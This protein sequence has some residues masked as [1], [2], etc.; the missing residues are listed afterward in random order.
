ML[1]FWHTY[2]QLK[3]VSCLFVLGLGLVACAIPGNYS[4]DNPPTSPPAELQIE[5]GFTISPLITGLDQPT[6]LAFDPQGRLYIAQRS[7][8][9]LIKEGADPPREYATGFNKPLSLHWFEQ[10]LYV[11]EQGQI[12]RLSDNNGDGIVDQQTILLSDLPDQ[13]EAATLVSDAQGWLYL[14]VGTQADHTAT[15]G[16]QEGYIRRFRADGSETS[17]YATGLRMPFGLAFNAQQ[18]LYAT[19]N[20]REGLGDDLPP[21]EVNRIEAGAN[22]GWPACWGQRQP[23]ADGGGDQAVCATTSEPV[24]LLPAHSGVTG[25][26]FYQG[27]TFPASYHGDGFIGLSGSWYSQELRGHSIVRLN[28]EDQRIVPFASGFARPVGL[29]ISPQGEL[30]VA[31]YDRGMIVM[32]AAKP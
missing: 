24:A 6:G 15:A 3:R 2:Q 9:V 30:L 11:V 32:I 21:D 1:V 10:A 4:S 5:A 20:G 27:T 25:I 18:Q 31:D 17:V 12:Q 14:G 13:I 29:V 19:D 16:I 22:Y 28:A 8:S 26:V 23:D 7:G